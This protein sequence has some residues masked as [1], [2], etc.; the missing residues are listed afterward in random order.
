MGGGGKACPAQRCPLIR[1]IQL[2]P[3]PPPLPPLSPLPILARAITLVTVRVPRRDSLP[4]LPTPPHAP[5][6]L[7]CP[8]PRTS[9]RNQLPQQHRISPSHPLPRARRPSTIHPPQ[10]NPAILAT[11]HIFVIRTI[12]IHSGI[13]MQRHI[14]TSFYYSL[15][16]SQPTLVYDVY[17][18]F[19]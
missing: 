10:T 16:F 14:H 19:V 17:D 8:L 7:Q 5:W 13:G 11:F 15:L 6:H 18:V 1:R 2:N 9:Q 4:Q 12:H 3:P